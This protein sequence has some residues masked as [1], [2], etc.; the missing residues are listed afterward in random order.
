MT[1][2][3]EGLS[4]DGQ[5]EGRAKRRD[6]FLTLYPLVTNLDQL[7]SAR[8]TEPVT[9]SVLRGNH[10]DPHPPQDLARAF[11]PGRARPHS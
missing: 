2:R 8:T 9:A 10:R 3:G 4:S 7:A 1:H 11:V 5:D 6:A